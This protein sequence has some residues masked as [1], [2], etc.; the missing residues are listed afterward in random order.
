MCF[1]EDKEALFDAFD[2][3]NY[4]IGISTGIIETLTINRDKMYA[5]LNVDFLLNDVF[6]VFNYFIKK[7]V[8]LIKAY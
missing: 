1:Q 5:A 6:N 2:T 8:S 7:G 4:L 3:I